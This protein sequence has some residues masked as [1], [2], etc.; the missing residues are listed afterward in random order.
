[1]PCHFNDERTTGHT[2]EVGLDNAFGGRVP[3]QPG[4]VVNIELVHH[5]LAMLFDG[6]NTQI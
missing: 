2:S 6:F 4:G 3:D 5:L 1:M